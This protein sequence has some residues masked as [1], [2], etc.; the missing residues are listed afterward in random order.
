MGMG[1]MLPLCLQGCGSGDEG[2]GGSSSFEW[3]GFV[4]LVETV[5]VTQLL[6]HGCVCVCVWGREGGRE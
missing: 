5:A 4:K 3:S 1:L 6:S 2:E